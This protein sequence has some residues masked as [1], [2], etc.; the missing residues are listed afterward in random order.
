[1]IAGIVP[2]AGCES[3]FSPIRSRARMIPDLTSSAP[4]GLGILRCWMSRVMISRA[5]MR[6]RKYGAAGLSVP[7]RPAGN[8][9]SP[10]SRGCGSIGRRRMAPAPIAASAGPDAIAMAPAAVVIAVGLVVT[11]DVAYPH[12]SVDT[13]TAHFAGVQQCQRESPEAGGDP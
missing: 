3:F 1:M 12:R 8:R 6:C 11:A 2:S 10:A 5:V 9:R 4:E 7:S 13:D